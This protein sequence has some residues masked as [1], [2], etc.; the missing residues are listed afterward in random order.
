[1][2]NA[3]STIQITQPGRTMKHNADHPSSESDPLHNLG[4]LLRTTRETRGLSLE[5]LSRRTYLTVAQLQA[6]EQGNLDALPETPY[7]LAHLRRLM[8]ALDL[9]KDHPL[10]MATKVHLEDSGNPRPTMA[11]LG[12]PT[13]PPSDEETTS[14]DLKGLICGVVV[15]AGVIAILFWGSRGGLQQLR[16]TFG[17]TPLSEFDL[18]RFRLPDWRLPQ[19][20][21][22]AIG[23]PQVGQQPND[24]GERPP[25]N[26][27]TTPT[28]T[29][30]ESAAPQLIGEASAGTAVEPLESAGPPRYLT[31]PPLGDPPADT[32]V[33]PLE[34]AGPSEPVVPPPL[35]EPPAGTVV[36]PLE[37][38][39]PSEPVAPPPLGNPPAGTAVEP[40]ESAVLPESSADQSIG[41]PPAG[42]VVEVTDPAD[43]SGVSD[44]AEPAADTTPAIGS[45]TP[46]VPAG[47]VR[48]D[49]LDTT[50]IQVRNGRGITLFQG[51]L[52]RSV[53]FPGSGGLQVRA[54]RPQLVRWST[55]TKSDQ[56]LDSSAAGVW[57][58]LAGVADLPVNTESP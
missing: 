2:T 25:L 56:T 6:L 40:L 47:M 17:S 23:P 7:L 32:A 4:A 5:Q 31:L 22:P 46:P 38:A 48:L 13:V 41:E 50:W 19:Q 28:P 15:G 12:T 34:S 45:D 55:T 18:S 39:G 29:P 27:L 14:L 21:P 24:P 49:F 37:S 52:N 26:D 8:G 54:R 16:R 35:G 36:E 51:Q 53:Q 33:K 20:N 57:S 10:Y 3:V 42:T 58:V 44:A 11:L 30:P 9:A 43:P 1:M